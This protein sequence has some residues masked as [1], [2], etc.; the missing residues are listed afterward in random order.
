VKNGAS[1]CN[2]IKS[3]IV[4]TASKLSAV[5][6]AGPSLWKE[7]GPTFLASRLNGSGRLHSPSAVGDYLGKEIRAEAESEGAAVKRWRET[8]STMGVTERAGHE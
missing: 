6:C 3:H 8:A 4:A 5:T 2:N 7:L 1:Q